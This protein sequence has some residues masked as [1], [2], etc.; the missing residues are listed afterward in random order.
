[1]NQR[2]GAVPTDH[3]ESCLINI[4]KTLRCLKS[5][6]SRSF[7][8]HRLCWLDA[9]F[10]DA[11]F[12]LRSTAFAEDNHHNAKKQLLC[13]CFA[14]QAAIC[15]ARPVDKLVE[16]GRNGIEDWEYGKHDTTSTMFYC[17]KC[18]WVDELSLCSPD[19][20]SIHVRKQI[21]QTKFSQF[22]SIWLFFWNEGVQHPSWQMSGVSCWHFWPFSLEIFGFLQILFCA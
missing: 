22:T 4:W 6:P 15:S 16:W 1:M 7:I 10:K 18:V 11:I 12:G 13:F 21:Y 9:G 14:K 3:P 8:N 19:I 17:S 5:L 2:C 20:S